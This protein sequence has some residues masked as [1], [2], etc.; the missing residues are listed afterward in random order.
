MNVEFF[1]IDNK[2][3]FTSPMAVVS[4][5]LRSYSKPPLSLAERDHLRLNYSNYL[6]CPHKLKISPF[7]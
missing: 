5:K 7:F 4:Q 2:F 3:K 6:A 1:E